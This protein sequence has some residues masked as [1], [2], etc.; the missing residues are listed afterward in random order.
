MEAAYLYDTPRLPD[1]NPHSIS[2]DM[3]SEDKDNSLT[4]IAQQKRIVRYD[5]ARKEGQDVIV[6]SSCFGIWT[7]TSPDGTL[8]FRGDEETFSLYSVTKKIRLGSGDCGCIVHFKQ[9]HRH[10][11]WKGDSVFSPDSKKMAL[12]FSTI[13]DDDKPHEAFWKA[14]IW[15]ISADKGRLE[16]I[17]KIKG[18]LVGPGQQMA[19]LA[20]SPDGTRIVAV[21]C[22]LHIEGQ[23][24]QAPGPSMAF[25]VWDVATGA[26]LHICM[27][28]LEIGETLRLKGK[29][30]HPFEWNSR[31]VLA[32]WFKETSRFIIWDILRSKIVF[33]RNLR[34]LIG[35]GKEDAQVGFALKGSDVLVV[36]ATMGCLQV[37]NAMHCQ[38]LGVVQDT[39]WMYDQPFLSPD[40]K[41]LVARSER[42]DKSGDTVGRVWKLVL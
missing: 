6:P 22:K 41:Y 30:I 42:K 36:R 8:V 20:F 28:P 2:F 7:R 23:Q 25:C 9:S 37:W 40:G 19:R 11:L 18:H 39:D 4:V 24:E 14:R 32:V 31:W 38:M 3:K 34:F 21:S 35:P 12:A 29:V 13:T 17:S 33:D 16:D 10:K 1:D 15:R 27:A 5:Q 26:T